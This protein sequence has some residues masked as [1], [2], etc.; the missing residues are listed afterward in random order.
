MSKHKEIDGKNYRMVIVRSR[1][2]QDLDMLSAKL[3]YQPGQIN[4]YTAE[5]LVP[6]GVI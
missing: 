5:V 6:G 4:N 2:Q 3:G 1:N